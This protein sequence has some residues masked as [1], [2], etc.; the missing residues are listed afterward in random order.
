MDL[1]TLLGGA[2]V[3]LHEPPVTLTIAGSDSGGGAGIQA[4]LK[5]FAACRTFGTS[6]LT[7]VT[8]QNTQGVSAVEVL[9][10]SVIMAQF[11]AVTTDIPPAA[12]KTGALGNSRVIGLIAELLEEYPI[13]KLVVD[14]VMVSKHGDPLLPD[15]AIKAFVQRMIPHAMV[16]TPNRFEAQTLIGREVEDI[17]DMQEA[18]KR[19]FD[20][21]AKYVLIK[22]GHL[23]HIV[24]D[25]LFDG[26]GFTEFGADR[27]RSP[28]VHGSG[29]T[30]SAAITARLAADDPIEHAIEFAR[31]FITNAI[32]MAPKI[33][34]GISPVNPMHAM[35]HPKTHGF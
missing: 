33:G 34:E 18:C 27:V 23:E 30:F 35:W 19:I 28:R 21:G 25:I 29:C 15:Q 14:P 11:K 22:G 31:E 3:S 5:T 10:D 20:M 2:G 1:F 24:R 4:D 9:S 13:A 32:L 8:A 6:V 17:R 16:I 12:A 7:L 26:T